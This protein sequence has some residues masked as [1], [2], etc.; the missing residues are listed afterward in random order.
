MNLFKKTLL[1]FWGG[2]TLLGL[3]SIFIYLVF[4]VETGSISSPYWV[5][6]LPYILIYGAN[7]LFFG[8]F[9]LIELAKK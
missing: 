4:P 1:F 2:Y 5:Y 8:L 3:V 6:D 7:A 9:F